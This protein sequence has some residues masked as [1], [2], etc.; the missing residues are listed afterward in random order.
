M[1]TAATVLKFDLHSMDQR[2]TIMRLPL[3]FLTATVVTAMLATV[4]QAEQVFP[5]VGGK[6]DRGEELRCPPGQVLVG[7]HGGTGLWIDR[8]GVTCGRFALPSYT[9]AFAKRHPPRGGGGGFNA[10]DCD[11]DAAI[12]RIKSTVAVSNATRKFVIT[13]RFV[14][15]RPRDGAITVEREFGGPYEPQPSG[16]LAYSVPGVVSGADQSCSG[17]DYAIGLSVRYGADVNAL[18]L[19]CGTLVADPAPVAPPFSPAPGYG[20]QPPIVDTLAATGCK[21]PFVHRKARPTDEVCVTRDSH[22]TVQGE[23]ATAPARWDPNGAYGP[24]T[25]VAGFVWREAFDGDVVCVTPER[26]G[27]VKEENRLAPTRRV[28]SPRPQF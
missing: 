21:P 10:Q 28:W 5:V 15:S 8:I 22:A 13:I 16:G 7:V 3:T 23:N 25:C 26:R 2:E 4:A 18:G 24:Y 17:S 14:C 11:L 1:G 6:G 9:L 12:R 20:Q 19:I 27:E